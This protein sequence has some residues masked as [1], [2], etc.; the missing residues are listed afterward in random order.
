MNTRS[1]LAICTGLAVPALVQPVAAEEEVS[2]AEQYVTT[3]I[4]LQATFYDII[5]KL[6]DEEITP[7]KAAEKITLLNTYLTNEKENTK[8]FTDDDWK[9][10]ETILADEEFQEQLE[11]I[12]ENTIDLL[13]EFKKNDYLGSK[14]L[15]KALEDFALISE[16]EI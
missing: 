8:K 13:R 14:A 4:I 10:I 12:I 11:E 16:Y 2:A 7:D 1:L 9:L 6:L 15:Q 5:D 3:M